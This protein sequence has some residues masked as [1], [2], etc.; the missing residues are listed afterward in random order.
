MCGNRHENRAAAPVLRDQLIF[1]QLLLYFINIGAWLIDL[2]D[3][4]NDLNSCRF[5]MVNGLYGLWHHAVV[6]RYNQDS[7]I[8]RLS[9]SHTH[10]G[11][12][13]MS[14]CIKEGDLS[15]IDLDHGSTDMLGDAA[16]LSCS[17]ICLADCIQK[18]GFTMVNMAH[19]ADYRR[20]GNHIFR[21][22]LVFL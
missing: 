2:V 14:R 12:R 16:C 17:Y 8:R 5:C 4:N 22:L 7:D 20:S 1:R 19:N 10:G 13:L 18:R 15:V 6:C 11:K 21:L 3:G 9:A